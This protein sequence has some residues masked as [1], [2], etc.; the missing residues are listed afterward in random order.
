MSTNFFQIDCRFY[1]HRYTKALLHFGNRIQNSEVTLLR[2]MKWPRWTWFLFDLNMKWKKKMLWSSRFPDLIPLKLP[3]NCPCM[4]IW[5]VESVCVLVVCWD[6]AASVWDVA[7]ADVDAVVRLSAPLCVLA[8]DKSTLVPTEL[9]KIKLGYR[10]GLFPA[11][12][13]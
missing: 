12:L 5:A 2:W 11:S 4:W 13:Q 1:G 3:T 9:G 7:G 10:M 6:H 8:R